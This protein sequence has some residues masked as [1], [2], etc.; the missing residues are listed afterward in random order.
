MQ[1][2]LGAHPKMSSMSTRFFSTTNGVV[3][4]VLLTG[5]M[6]LPLAAGAQKETFQHRTDSANRTP[7]GG[8]YIVK[9]YVEEAAPGS[10]YETGP[11]H[12]IYSDGLDVVQKLPPKKESTDREIVQ[13]QEG[14][15]EPQLA[16]DKKTMGW[17]ETFDNV[18]TSYAVPLVLVLYRSGKI[19][20]SIQQGQMVWSWA[21]VDGGKKVAVVWGLTHGPEVGDFQLY[22][23]NTGRMLSEV[24]GDSHIQGLKPNAPKWAKKLEK[25]LNDGQK[26]E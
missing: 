15:S 21:F 7:A 11:L 10:A 8:S 26:R 23:V 14:I 24:F 17:T 13:N 6:M 5:M 16:E 4:L 18:G 20:R 19:I 25:Q 22:D 1:E 3:L 12:I 2:L 9:Y